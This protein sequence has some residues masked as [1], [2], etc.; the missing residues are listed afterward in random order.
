ML[1]VVGNVPTALADIL[2]KGVRRRV[3]L[4]NEKYVKEIADL[5]G[6]TPIILDAMMSEIEKASGTT[7]D[8]IL[9]S[10]AGAVDFM[11][12][13]HE[14]MTKPNEITGITLGDR[15]PRLT[16]VLD[17]IQGKK[18]ITVSANQSV[19]KTTLLANFLDE[20]A[21]GQGKPWVHFS[22][23]MT[24]PEI[25]S[26][27]IGIRAGVNGRKIARGNLTPEEYGAVQQASIEYHEGNLLII[28][29][30]R[31]LES[32]TNTIRKLKRTHKIAGVSI[33]Y[34]QLM[35]VER[36]RNKQRYEELGDISGVLKTDIANKLDIP[37]I[38]LSQLSRS[39]LQKAVATAEDGAGSYKI[40]Q[41]SD[42]YITLK[43]KTI[44]EIEEQG[45]IERG[46]L[47]LNVDKNRGGEAD[48]LLDIYFQK[49]VQRMLE[50]RY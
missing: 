26:K 15:F 7:V 42:I 20:I 23:E 49:D 18:L 46:N 39:A 44:E 2:D 19:G 30:Q 10:S 9:T 35:S 25:V 11:A 37:V 36:N 3:T 14:R 32:I 16:D 45:G 4:I 48:V 50:V 1:N 24:S 47:V 6:K 28:D 40:A 38:I 5:S 17:G 21:I 43:E 34:V 12:Q 13:L 8:N 41:D 31:T 22:L 29:D 33:D 27:I